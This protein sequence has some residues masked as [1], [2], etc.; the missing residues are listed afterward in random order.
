MPTILITPPAELPIDL[1]DV[2]A[3]LRIDDNSED[4]L[5]TSYINAASDYIA[6]ATGSQLMRATYES[7]FNG[8][9]D[10]ADEDGFQ[11]IYLPYPPLAAVVSVQYTD[12]DGDTQSLVSG[13]DYSA[14]TRCAPGRIVPYYGTTWPTARDEPNSVTVRFTAGYATKDDVPHRIRQAIRFLCGHYDRIKQPVITG[15]IQAQVDFTL[16]SLLAV[17]KNWSFG[18]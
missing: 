16:Q 7:T 1:E 18:G 6:R 8:F 2:K 17:E 13:T 15:T 4:S 3:H 11:S 14:D 12:T 10:C 5:I 9:P